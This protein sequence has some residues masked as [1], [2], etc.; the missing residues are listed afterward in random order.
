MGSNLIKEGDSM[1]SQIKIVYDFVKEFPEFEV[2]LIDH[3]NF[4]E[5]VLPHVFFGDEVNPVLLDSLIYNKNSE[6][7][8]DLFTFF[9]ER[10]CNSS[11]PYVK[12]VLTTTIL[13]RIGD[14]R[15]AL[16]NAF[17]FAGPGVLN[18]MIEIERYLERNH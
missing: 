7:L 6:K 5:E 9:E 10:M 16:K 17:Q 2:K 12:N 8:R 13:A 18:L 14:E 1:E 11:E 3:I 15:I 4:N